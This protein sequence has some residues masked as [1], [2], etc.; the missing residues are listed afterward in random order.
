MN[1]R[2]RALQWG[3]DG[4]N[5]MTNLNQQHMSPFPKLDR[6]IRNQRWLAM[7]N[8]FVTFA[9]LIGTFG[10]VSLLVL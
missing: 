1:P 7:A 6:V 3:T 9:V 5:A 2:P 8:G 4:G 10:I